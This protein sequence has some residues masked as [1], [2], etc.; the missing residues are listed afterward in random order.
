MDWLKAIVALL[1]AIRDFFHAKENADARQAG[2]DA[3][4]A[5]TLRQQAD[6]VAEARRIESEPDTGE[7]DGFRRD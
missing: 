7:D 4:N 6:R 5:D 2:R 3:A 1:G